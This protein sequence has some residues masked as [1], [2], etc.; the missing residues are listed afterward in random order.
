MRRRWAARGVLRC[1]G[2]RKQHGSPS[3]SRT[4]ER[5]TPAGCDRETGL[6]LLLWC[7]C[8]C[9]LLGGCIPADWDDCSLSGTSRKSRSQDLGNPSAGGFSNSLKWTQSS[10]M[11]TAGGPVS[12]KFHPFPRIGSRVLLFFAHAPYLGEVLSLLPTVDGQP[13]VGFRACCTRL[14]G[15]EGTPDTKSLFPLPTP[16]ATDGPLPR[17][18]RSTLHG[19]PIFTMVRIPLRLPWSA[20]TIPRAATIE[21]AGDSGG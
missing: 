16:D 3:S 18:M 5:K 13:P 8:W 17:Q 4:W 1:E 7:C 2:T 14:L 20:R 11:A 15:G 21:I 6:L 12:A 19:A 10:L 9:S